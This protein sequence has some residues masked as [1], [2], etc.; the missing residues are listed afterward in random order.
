[1]SEKYQD[2]KAVIE[3]DDGWKAVQ[4]RERRVGAEVAG[5]GLDRGRGVLISV[6]R[7]VTFGSVVITDLSF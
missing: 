7:P 6:H 5:G 2:E 3:E 4:E 1:M